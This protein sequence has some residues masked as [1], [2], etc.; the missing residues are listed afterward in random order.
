MTT[1][2]FMLTQ[3]NEFMICTVNYRVTFHNVHKDKIPKCRDVP[4]GG[5][6]TSWCELLVIQ[7]MPLEP[8]LQEIKALKCSVRIRNHTISYGEQGTL[9]MLWKTFNNFMK[10]STNSRHEQK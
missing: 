6:L 9:Y 10:D 3:F 4:P 1:H 8:T 7:T 2:V 5:K